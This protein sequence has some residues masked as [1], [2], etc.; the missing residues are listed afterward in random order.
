[1]RASLSAALVLLV[2]F[3]ACFIVLI[4][5]DLHRD[6]AD[7]HVLLENTAA[8]TKHFDQTIAKVDTA[9]DTLNEA[10]IEERAN[11]KTTSKEAAKTG[12]ALR[13]L[14][15]DFRKSSIHMNLVTIPAIDAQIAAN[16]NQLQSTIR[17]LGGTADGLTETTLRL[18]ARL[19]DPQIP[20]LLGQLNVSARQLA[21]ASG[22]A[23]K[24]LGDG[25]KVADHYE[26]EIMA[27]VSWGKRIG[28]YLLTFGS[29]ARVLFTG[30][31]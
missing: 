25:E 12:L 19:D 1:M 29:D 5:D 10:A 16:G 30:G 6:L 7:V 31:K 26:A 20:Q 17:K 3:A 27:P 22:H 24:I 8:S 14:I 28:E 11:W 18:N 9:A 15:D 4:G 2:S 23:N 13:E 21:E